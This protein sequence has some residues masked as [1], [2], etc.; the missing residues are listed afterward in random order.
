MTGRLSVIRLHESPKCVRWHIIGDTLLLLQ[1]G[2]FV[3]KEMHHPSGL[4]VK[5]QVNL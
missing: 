5:I 4:I 3:L 1:S 2:V